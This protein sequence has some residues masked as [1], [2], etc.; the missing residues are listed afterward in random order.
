MLRQYRFNSRLEKIERALFRDY[1][2]KAKRFAEQCR[3]DFPDYV[4]YRNAYL[5]DYYQG[6]ALY[7]IAS[8]DFYS[9]QA[10]F[11]LDTSIY[12]LEYSLE[13]NHTF[14]DAH[15]VACWVYVT[16]IGY[17]NSDSEKQNFWLKAKEHAGRA[18]TLDASLTEEADK[19]LRW[20]NKIR[21]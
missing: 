1:P 4:Q 10:R 13:L 21:I 20:L 8:E 15:M 12:L 11:Y 3:V 6:Q 5:L 9:A 2:G 14:S 17:A 18:K 16:K 19:M 7:R